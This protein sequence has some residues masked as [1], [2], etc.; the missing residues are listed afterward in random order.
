MCDF[1]D[2]K[3]GCYFPR[4]MQLTL[5]EDSLDRVCWYSAADYPDANDDNM[6]EATYGLV[7][8]CNETDVE[9]PYLAKSGFVM[10][11]YYNNLFA[12]SVPLTDY[13]D[14]EVFSYHSRSRHGNDI[15]MLGV[16]DN[17][18]KAV[19]YNLGCLSVTVGDAYGNEHMLY[20]DD[21][22]FDFVLNP[23]EITY[24]QGNFS[25]ITKCESRFSVDEINRIVEENEEVEIRFTAKNG[26]DG[27]LVIESSCGVE[28]LSAD[29]A[30]V[31]GTATA[32]IKVLPEKASFAQVSFRVEKDGKIY[33]YPTVELDYK[34]STS[35]AVGEVEFET[36]FEIMPKFLKSIYKGA[37]AKLV[38]TD[39]LHQKALHIYRQYENAESGYTESIVDFG[40]SVRQGVLKLSYS[41]KLS[42]NSANLLQY[43]YT[44]NEKGLQDCFA[45]LGT[46]EQS[47]YVN[48]WRGFKA[49]LSALVADEWCLI[50]IVIDFDNDCAYLY[51]DGVLIDYSVELM[52]DEIC[53]IMFQSHT[54]DKTDGGVYFDDL[55]ISTVQDDICVTKTEISGK[56][57]VL[58]L[59]NTLK[60]GSFSLERKKAVANEG[61][62]PFESGGYSSVY[63]GSNTHLGWKLYETFNTN[64]TVAEHIQ[65]DKGIRTTGNYVQTVAYNLG[66]LPVAPEY[67]INIS[68]DA[69]FKGTDMNGAS[70]NYSLEAYLLENNGQSVWAN[71]T[72]TR[73]LTMNYIGSNSISYW[74]GTSPY[75]SSATETKLVDSVEMNKWYTFD[76]SIRMGE[77]GN[78]ITD[79]KVLDSDGKVLAEEK[80]K[81]LMNESFEKPY[82]LAFVMNT[83]NTDSSTDTLKGTWIDNLSIDYT[84]EYDVE[85]IKVGTDEKITADVKV[86]SNRILQLTVPY[87]LEKGEE[88]AVIIPDDTR[89]ESVYGK[90]TDILSFN[91]PRKEETV[92]IVTETFDD[93]KWN[94]S[95]FNPHYTNGKWPAGWYPTVGG[96]YDSAM[97][98]VYE[99]GEYYMK[100]GDG[101]TTN[102]PHSPSG[103]GLKYALPKLPDKSSV[104]VRYDV[105][106][107]PGSGTTSS[108]RAG[109]SSAVATE[110]NPSTMNNSQNLRLGFDIGFVGGSGAT[111]A[112][113]FVRHGGTWTSS[114]EN[115]ED[116][117]FNA[118]NWYT[119]ETVWN[120]DTNNSKTYA[121]YRAWDKL[122]GK[123]AFTP[124]TNQI[125]SLSASFVPKAAGVVLWGS[126]RTTQILLD[127]MEIFYTYLPTGIKHFRTTE[128]G[129]SKLPTGKISADT[130]TLLLEFTGRTD[131][132]AYLTEEDGRK[133]ALSGIEAGNVYEWNIKEL[134]VPNQNYNLL[135]VYDNGDKTFERSLLA[136]DENEAAISNYGIYNADGSR[137][138]RWSDIKDITKLYVNA[139]IG[140]E[141]GVNDNATLTFVLLEKGILIDT[142]FITAKDCVASNGK[143]LLEKPFSMSEKCDEI[144]CFLW[145]DGKNIKPLTKGIKILKNQ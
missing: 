143:Y 46:T 13:S 60:D 64:T 48:G 77:A 136:V 87:E 92:N 86:L 80:E 106:I 100:L 36:D 105:K 120:I 101:G 14:T 42:G 16:I 138:N 3:Q 66:N 76:Y 27:K 99:N 90:T 113:K 128:N 50:D 63:L 41:Q 58:Y 53:G 129:E 40:T 65:G 55:K 44:V 12:N 69:M 91:I 31:N 145:T 85:I 21:G 130:E 89:L 20:S 78:H 38:N 7:E 135:V 43:V 98:Q 67:T 142:G 71:N 116:S 115:I 75:M 81:I 1:N 79:Y 96:Q 94:K 123:E 61:I 34:L 95:S 108:N 24:I 2:K 117:V 4:I 39:T 57:I 84:Y 121:Q 10:A 45:V 28:V 47:S 107:L 68:Y 19:S 33:F 30:F 112:N 111:N 82:Q 141:S 109:L 122:S 37:E 22:V 125:P 49:E 83:N 15:L 137:V 133:T 26:F 88:Y 17:T 104:T 11:A 56:D 127:N 5:M 32:K 72:R 114:V 74:T 124:L 54:G 59:N 139:D 93:S 102:I 126:E 51:R 25:G 144:R 62:E 18:S 132:V 73:L 52:V 110:L 70:K 29:A 119:C 131:A 118:D 35:E 97:A 134:L 8:G 140:V 6:S 23:Y 9:V 103:S